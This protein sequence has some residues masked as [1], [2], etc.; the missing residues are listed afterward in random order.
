LKVMERFDVSTHDSIN[1][2][3]SE[4][5]VK[6]RHHSSRDTNSSILRQGPH[7]NDVGITNSVGQNTRS[8]DYSIINIRDN[9]RIAILEGPA[10]LFGSSSVVEV[11]G[12]KYCLHPRPIDV[13]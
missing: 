7:V 10:Q 4:V 9:G 11:V 1:K 8:A 6:V 2:S 13:R 5:Q 12:R 3:Q